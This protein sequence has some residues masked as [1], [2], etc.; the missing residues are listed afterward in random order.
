[1][2]SR[3]TPLL[4]RPYALSNRDVVFWRF[5]GIG[6]KVLLDMILNVTQAKNGCL[7]A[8]ILDYEKG[9]AHKLF[10]SQAIGEKLPGSFVPNNTRREIFRD[11]KA[12]Y[13]IASNTASLQPHVPTFFGTPDV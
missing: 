3:S 5:G 10:F 1:M 2:N 7:A 8:V 11:E 6:V 13:K 12:A 4:I 9:R